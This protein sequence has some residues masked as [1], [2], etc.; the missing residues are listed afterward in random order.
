LRPRA[1]TL[2]T[3]T[4][5]EERR[6]HQGFKRSGKTFS[7][8]NILDESVVSQHDLVIRAYARVMRLFAWRQ[9]GILLYWNTP[10]PARRLA[11]RLQ[12][13]SECAGYF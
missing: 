8:M 10:K 6:N 2:C 11:E 7:A 12:H 9:P 4:N 5:E 13:I 3:T 1:I